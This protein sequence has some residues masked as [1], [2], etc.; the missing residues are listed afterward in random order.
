DP[1]DDIPTSR[2]RPKL[3]VLKHLKGNGPASRRKAAHGNGQPAPAPAPAAVAEP[4]APPQTPVTPGLRLRVVRGLK[5]N[6]EYPLFEG[7]NLI[8]RSDDR[9]VDI[10]IRDQEPRDRVWT[11]RHHAVI[12]LSAGG[13]LT[14][15]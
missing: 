4:P 1:G 2:T 14:I 7:Q 15:E 11:S 9:P 12:T 10:D 3:L 13:V 8:G 6:V 5:V